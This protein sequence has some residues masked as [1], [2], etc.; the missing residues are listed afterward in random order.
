MEKLKNIPS[1]RFPEFDGEWE[2]KNLGEICK[3]QAGKFI[4]ALDIKNESNVNQYPCYGGNGL[5][6]YT[7]TYNQDGKYS[8]IGRQGAHCGNV[9]VGV[10]KFYATEHAVVV[11][12]KDDSNTDF[13]FYILK[14]LNLN[15][16]STG[17]A[18]PGLSVQNLDKIETTISK[19]ITEQTKIASF[20]SEVDYKLQTLKQKKKLLEHY[21]KGVMQK[22]FSQKLRF[23]YDNGNEYP[24][25]EE[26]KLGEVLI[27]K[28]EKTSSS[29]QHRILS[30]TAK[31]IFNQDEY[32]TR[33]IASKDNTGYKILRKYQ[34]VFSPQNLW[35][36]NIN[37]NMNFEIGIVSPSYKIFSFDEKFTIAEYCQYF[38]LTPK[39]MF[40]YEQSSTQGASVVRRNLDMDKFLSIEFLLPSVDE[41]TKIA[42]FLSAIDD[43]INHCQ[44]QI[45]KMELWKKGLLQQMFV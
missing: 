30:S 19:S 37:V 24:D 40:E 29:G 43:K 4:N 8:L 1:L 13:I 5:R 41:Q 3:M 6:G 32:F 45:E 2:I 21:K 25:W 26:K 18:Q 35:L 34:L 14:N 20:L 27:E 36:G 22:I 39:M 23:K 10:G 11:K 38:L 28:N 15:Q 12:L 33:D 9:N 42:N 44:V 7:N 16:Y 17:L 31:G